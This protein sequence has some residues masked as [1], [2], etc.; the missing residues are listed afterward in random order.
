MAFKH[1]QILLGVLLLGVSG[2]F[3]Q[4]ESLRTVNVD[5]WYEVK[6]F[7]FSFFQFMFKVGSKNSSKL[8]DGWQVCF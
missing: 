4:G 1:Y 7:L 6:G 5:D 8:M 3:S 2:V